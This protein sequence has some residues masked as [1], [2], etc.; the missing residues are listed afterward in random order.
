MAVNLQAY[1]AE[2][3]AEAITANKGGRAPLQLLLREND[4]YRQVTLDWRGG[5][6]YPV[7]QR[8]EGTPDRLTAIQSPR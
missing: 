3:L 4:Q 8:A 7:L 5:L 6:R 1:K 2:R